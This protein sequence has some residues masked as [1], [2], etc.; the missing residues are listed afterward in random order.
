M[1]W[2]Y[3]GIVWG[4]FVMCFEKNLILYILEVLLIINQLK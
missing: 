1:L 4:K 3:G 2:F